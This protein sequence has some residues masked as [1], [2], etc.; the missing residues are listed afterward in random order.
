MQIQLTE[1]GLTTS[2]AHLNPGDEIPGFL[3]LKEPKGV[4][5]RKTYS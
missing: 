3:L 1:K 5:E 2:D 4:Y